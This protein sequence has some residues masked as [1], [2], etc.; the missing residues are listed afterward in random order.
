VTSEDVSVAHFLVAR[1][2][3]QDRPLPV[4]DSEITV[5]RVVRVGAYWFFRK[6]ERA[7]VISFSYT[8]IVACA[9][10]RGWVERPAVRNHKQ[11]EV[12]VPSA[13]GTEHNFELV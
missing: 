12:G 6:T 5:H 11:P 1:P 9:K 8:Q 7:F 4:K 10:G 13:M 2:L 3:H